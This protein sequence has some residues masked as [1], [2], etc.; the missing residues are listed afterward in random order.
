MTTT[1]FGGFPGVRAVITPG[2]IAGVQV[3]REQKLVL[4]GRADTNAGSASANDPT[5]IATR[6]DARSKFGEKTELALAM[7][8]ALNNGANIDYIYGVALDET[9]VLGDN[10]RG[11]AG[12]STKLDDGVGR[13]S[14]DPIV[15]D[16]DDITIE[17][18]SNNEKT[19]V[20]RHESPPDA[21]SVESGEVAVNPHT[22]EIADPDGDS[23][24]VDYKIADWQAAFDAADRVVNHNETG[25]YCA[26]SDTESVAAEL[27]TKVDELAPTWKLIKGIA[28]A[29]PNET[30]DFGEAGYDTE[31]YDDGI[32]NDRMFL[33]GSVRIQGQ[34][35]QQ[36]TILGGIA[37]LFA[38]HALINPVYNDSIDGFVG[39]S[40]SLS[41]ADSDRLRTANVI[42]VNDERL[43]GGQGL[44]L[45]GN[46]STSDADGWVRDFHRIRIVDQ[47][48]MI[49]KEL[50]EQAVSNLMSDNLLQSLQEDYEA[51]L[52]GLVN[53]GLLRSSR[54][55]T[56]TNNNLE[57][58]TPR[59]RVE[60]SDTGRDFD[61]RGG[62]DAESRYFVEV[63]R[64]SR[65]TIAIGVG[66]TPV[67]IARKVDETI[68]ISE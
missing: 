57:D 38:G 68:V 3:G 51:E 61:A 9:Q 66:F 44:R 26:L 40:E 67:G 64:Q 32:N 41:G 34:T 37:G 15:E 45:A 62:D 33:A 55:G 11:A 23:L 36:R 14:N 59:E 42:P 27:S 8:D 50:G 65:D 39:V 19:P 16:V 48:L 24:T 4:F 31:N 53:A 12:D 13:L 46:H 6:V 7:E 1:T 56:L 35:D 25:I 20:F 28:G 49:G 43:D 17:D 52:T 2:G 60:E 47:V 30:N 29:Q 5:T 18:G 21:S 63:N 22:G 58:N 10:G 54:E